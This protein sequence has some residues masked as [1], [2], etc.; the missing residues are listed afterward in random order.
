ML[1]LFGRRD[2]KQSHCDGF[3]RRDFLKVGG[4]AAGGL[5]LAQLLGMEAKAG[6][7]SS[8]KAIINIYLPGG[9]S[10][11]DMF[12]LKPDAPSEIRGDFRPIGTNVPGIQICELFPRLAR[13]A[14]KFAIIRSLAD[15]DGAHDC[16]QCMTG[17]KRR[18]IGPAGGWPAFGSWVSKVQGSKPGIPANLS[19]MYPTGN[20]T[21]GESGTGGF[22][23]NSHAPM[24]LVDK[25]P[26]VRAKSMTLNGMSLDRLMD[27]EA[28]RSS[29]DQLHSEIDRQGQMEGLDTYNQQ[30]LEILSDGNLAAALDISRE[31]PKVAARYGLNDP[32]YQRDGAPKM[33][34]NFLVARRL[35]EAG[36]RVVSL[37]YSRWDWHGGD[38]LNFPRSREEFPLLDQGLS[39][40]ITD[41]HDR[42]MQDDVSIV[43]WGEFGRTPKINKMN[44]RDHWPNANF[45]FLAGGGMNTGQVIGATDRGGHEPVERPIKFQEIFATL[46]HNIGIDLA[47]ATVEDSSGRPH[48]LVDPGIKPIRELVG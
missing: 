11:L 14:D 8:H 30:A 45:V 29:I 2:R 44:S 7:G 31:D 21:W 27:R 38:G 33:I 36:A 43:M 47:S 3:S 34:R 41:L 32:T 35:V 17:H 1:E 9:P 24:G 37:N 12:D 39:A 15:S 18:D 42:G 19:L 26:K 4:M 46:Y 28:L 16:H 48:F 23:G 25:D 6:T 10:H 13:M 40:L 22:I 5:S 20:R